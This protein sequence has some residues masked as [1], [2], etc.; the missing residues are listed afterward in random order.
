MHIPEGIERGVMEDSIECPACDGSGKTKIPGVDDTLDYGTCRLCHGS[1]K[2]NSE[3][4]V[5][6]G[7][8]DACSYI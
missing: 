7:E 5:R 8:E 1:G 3:D 6:M 2:I 4:V